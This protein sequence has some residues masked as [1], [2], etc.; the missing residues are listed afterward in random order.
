MKKA[1]LAMYCATTDSFGLLFNREFILHLGFV[2]GAEDVG[3]ETSLVELIRFCSDPSVYSNLRGKS[4]FEWV[5]VI[6]TTAPA[7]T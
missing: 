7:S 1:T 2:V 4:C 6:F 3:M 5:K